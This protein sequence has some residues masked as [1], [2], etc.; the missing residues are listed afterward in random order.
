[1]IRHTIADFGLPIELVELHVRAG[2]VDGDAE[3]ELYVLLS[4]QDVD[5]KGTGNVNVE[6][7]VFDK[8]A[9][10]ATLL[11]FT[12]AGLASAA[13]AE[14]RTPQVDKPRLQAAAKNGAK[15]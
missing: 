9:T 12:T 5:S 11:A 6:G 15:S 4:H 13:S 10:A 2:N 7:R 3:D 1:M 8:L 14:P